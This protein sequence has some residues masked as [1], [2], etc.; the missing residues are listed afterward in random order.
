MGNIKVLDLFGDAILL[1]K[2][3]ICPSSSDSQKEFKSFS[4]YYNNYLEFENILLELIEKKQILIL[5]TFL[6]IKFFQ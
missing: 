1:N 4:S 5:Q 3:L 2:H 6:V